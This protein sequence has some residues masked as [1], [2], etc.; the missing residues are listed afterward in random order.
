[1]DEYL[2][3]CWDI[4]ADDADAPDRHPRGGLIHRNRRQELKLGTLP[5]WSPEDFI[6]YRWFRF[7]HII[8]RVRFKRRLWG[9]LGGV[10]RNRFPTVGKELPGRRSKSLPPSQS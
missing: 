8:L 2:D 6:V 10:L 7:T 9:L 5:N 1:M 3:D 4:V